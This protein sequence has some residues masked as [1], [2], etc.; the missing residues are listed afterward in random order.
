LTSSEDRD[1]LGGEAKMGFRGDAGRVPKPGAEKD[2][3]IL[4]RDRSTTL[5]VNNAAE[6]KA[7]YLQNK[8]GTVLYWRF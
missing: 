2:I 4:N 3:L 1:I 5:Y 6:N 8:R 7:P